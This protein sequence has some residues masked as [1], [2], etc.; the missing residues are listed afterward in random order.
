MN[1][2][3]GVALERA[4]IVSYITGYS[5]CYIVC[6]IGRFQSEPRAHYRRIS[7]YPE[8]FYIQ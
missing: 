1:G 6:Y 5:V 7:F 4:Y 3:L 2:E 8:W